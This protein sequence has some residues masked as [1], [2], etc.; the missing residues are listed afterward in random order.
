MRTD[1][2]TAPQLRRDLERRGL[3]VSALGPVG[4]RP[5]L[6]KYIS[7]LWERRHFI[8]MDSRHRITLQNSR[9]RLGNLWLILR[10]LFDAAMYFVIFGMILKADRGIDNFTAY[11]I[12]GVL[13]FRSTMQ[14]LSQSPGTLRVGKPMIRAFSFPRAALPISAQLR[15]SMQMVLTV[16]VMLAMI[17]V[18]PNHEIPRLSWLLVIPI[19]LMQCMLN[20]GVSLLMSRVGFILPDVS[21]VITVLSR[22]LM[23]GSGVI[24]PIDNYLTHPVAGAIIQANPIYQLLHMY[25][26]VLMDGT[27]PTVASWVILA[28]WCVG[29][30]IIGFVFFW[31]GEATY[32]DEQR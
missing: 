19:F 30:L 20:L 24:F 31:R 1:V 27:A 4:V 11:I 14:S 29:I 10:P 2:R 6:P 7:D 22:V 3:D 17:V 9:N 26:R 13:M 32:G 15:E 5:S 16:V 25:R 18:L 8:W 12:I 28:V 21:Q 23:Y